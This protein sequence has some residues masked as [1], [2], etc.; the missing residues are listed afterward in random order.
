MSGKKS[1]L[2]TITVLILL[3]SACGTQLR[4]AGPTQTAVPTPF[5]LPLTEAEV[6]RLPVEEAKAA[7]DSGTAVI[8]DVRSAGA[9]ES[10]HIAGAI[11]VELG[12]IETDPEGLQLNKDQWIITY[13]T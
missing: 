3:A 9:F 10:G 7:L 12:E 4:Q 11:N 1:V 5:R 13:C 6:P 2:F 8:V